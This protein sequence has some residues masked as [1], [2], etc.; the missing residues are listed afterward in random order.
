MNRACCV[1]HHGGAA[2]LVHRRSL[3]G[4]GRVVRAGQGL[5][6]SYHQIAGV[7]H[8]AWPPPKRAGLA[9]SSRCHGLAR[10]NSAR[11]VCVPEGSTQF[12]DHVEHVRPTGAVDENV[13]RLHVRAAAADTS[14]DR[15]RDL[16]RPRSAAPAVDPGTRSVLRAIADGDIRN[17]AGV[18]GY[19]VKDRI[20]CAQ[21]DTYTWNFLCG[22]GACS[23]RR[24]AEEPAAGARGK[25]IEVGN[26]KLSA[27]I[28]DRSREAAGPGSGIDDFSL[29]GLAVEVL[30]KQMRAAV[31]V[32]RPACLI[33]HERLSAQLHHKRAF[34]H[35]FE[36]PDVGVGA[37]SHSP[38]AYETSRPAK[39]GHRLGQARL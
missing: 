26:V 13:G 32:V 35:G 19:R 31:E 1:Y 27:R 7:Q 11:L 34:L 38:H 36:S 2:T 18:H 24:I 20:T 29:P 8:I 21:A 10:P 37:G 39:D 6:L 22:P 12:V 17:T 15:G 30:V 14:V 4:P 16:A 33:V 23:P 9:T 5:S 25:F 28:D 3:P